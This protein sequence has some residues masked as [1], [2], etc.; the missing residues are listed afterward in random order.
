MKNIGTEYLRLDAL[1]G[2]CCWPLSLCSHQ[3]GFPTSRKPISRIASFGLLHKS[4]GV[5]PTNE[6]ML[7]VMR[8]IATVGTYV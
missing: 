5:S 4:D 7:D 3:S 6:E 1:P 2:C 8:Y